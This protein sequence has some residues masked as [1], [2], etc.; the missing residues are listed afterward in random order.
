MSMRTCQ[1]GFL[2]H[3]PGI[4]DMCFREIRIK[5][6]G[7][8]MDW[9]KCDV[10]VV[11][12]GGGGLRAALA[13]K[14]KNPALKVVLAT[15]GKL[16]KSGTTA[17]ACSDRMAFHVTLAQTK[18][19]GPASFWYHA[20]DIYEIG[21]R[22][23]DGNLA[24]IL[25][26]R[27]ADA[28]DYLDRLGVPFVRKGG[29]VDQFVTDGSEFARAC[30]TGPKTAVHIEEALVA[31]VRKTDIEICERCMVVELLLSEGKVAG[32]LAVQKGGFGGSEG[33]LVFETANIILATGGAGKAYR[34]NVYPGGMTGDACGLAY[35][36]GA[37]LVNM[38]FIQ[39]GIA[40]LKTKLNCSGS[41]LRAVPRLVNDR[42][43]EFLPGYYPEGTPPEEIF[44]YVFQKGA[45]WP[46]TFE[47]KTHVIDLA[48]YKEIG[49]GRR[50]YLDYGENPRG[51]VFDN[52]SLS[53]RKRY[54]KEIT[55]DLGLKERRK[56]PLNRLKEINGA[57]IAWLKERGI[58]LEAGERIE[59]A[60]CIQHFQ[61]G[62]KI[63]GKGDTD[64]EGLYAV[65]ECAGGQHGANR[66]GGNALLDGQVFGKIA[67][68]AAAARAGGIRRRE[69]KPLSR[70][71]PKRCLF[72]LK[73]RFKAASGMSGREIRRRLREIMNREA[74]VVR[75]EAGLKK[76][77]AR[78]ESFKEAGLRQ[79]PGRYVYACE[80]E[81]LLL[82]AEMILRAAALRV[83]SRGP[84]LTFADYNDLKPVDK[85]DPSW[86]RYIV[87]REREGRMELQPEK[88]LPLPGEEC[89]K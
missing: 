64:I 5:K 87:I 79:E 6:R 68:T 39:I 36:A 9:I 43:E 49:K 34:H 77:L 82:T 7:R 33:F 84:H 42:G 19:G 76:A 57:T 50:V 13:A 55:V 20:R 71:E 54:G 62:V 86:Q 32:A 60:A 28:F 2:R 22:V 66:P 63:G 12:G 89:F 1:V 27:A 37:S 8:K 35:R 73:E 78:L 23:S 31:A 4:C 74:S 52:L 3:S 44:N 26:W 51:F 58:D 21:G 15:K 29:V 85:M 80:T 75:T 81:N 14:E 61:G 41:A 45:S 40:S 16:G 18:P 30:Y 24:V 56:N 17:L 53:N 67:G 83:E 72:R 25:A 38:E 69:G 10:L 48:V 11:G 47:H 46:V 70:E 88:P 59:I 65:G